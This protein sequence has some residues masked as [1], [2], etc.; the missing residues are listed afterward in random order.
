M[1]ARRKADGIAQELQDI[2]PSSAMEEA[3]F[4]ESHRTVIQWIYHYCERHGLSATKEGL[5]E[6]VSCSYISRLGLEYAHS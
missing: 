6:I 2:Q 3:H 1:P 4:L 5:F